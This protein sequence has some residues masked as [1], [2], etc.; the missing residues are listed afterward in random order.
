M[1]YTP[2]QLADAFLQAGEWDDALDALGQHLTDHPEDDERRRL[3]ARLHART[4]A[5]LRAALRD[6]DA[7]RA[8]GPE[9]AIRRSDYLERLDDLDAAFAALNRACAE[10]PHHER[11]LER[12]VQLHTASGNVAEARALLDAAPDTWR[13]RLWAGTL[14]DAAG[15]PVAA[16]THYAAALEGLRAA[17]G[18]PAPALHPLFAQAHLGMARAHLREARLDEAERDCRAAAALVPDDPAVPFFLGLIAAERGDLDHAVQACQRALAS[19]A[20]E[21]RA[22]FAQTL[23]QPRYQA[24]AERLNG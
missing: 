4:D 20:T 2:L 17:E 18:P 22:T 23:D 21:V 24:L 5:G 14:A 16:R 6:L 11:L 8:P 9:D 3:R 12:C 7:L 13:W 15:D 19:A 1:A 10:H